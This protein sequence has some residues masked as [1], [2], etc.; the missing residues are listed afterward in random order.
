VCAGARPVT[1]VTA[2]AP[3]LRPDPMVVARGYCVFGRVLAAFDSELPRHID[4]M[5]SGFA[6]DLDAQ[7]RMLHRNLFL[8]HTPAGFELRVLDGWS[9]L[10]RVPLR[11]YQGRH[12]ASSCADAYELVEALSEFFGRDAADERL[13]AA[14]LDPQ[15][16]S[17][18]DAKTLG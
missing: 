17:L 16:E 11:P 1:P 5:Q 8:V 12:A 9:V 3:G 7:M 2:P 4:D 13:L 14:V 15:F 18:E 6:L 10:L